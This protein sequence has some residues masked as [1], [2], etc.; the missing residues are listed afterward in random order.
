MQIAVAENF[1]Y[2]VDLSDDIGTI[3]L[4]ISPEQK[5]TMGSAAVNLLVASV[6]SGIEPIVTATKLIEAG[7]GT[8][9]EKFRRVSALAFPSP[10]YWQ[11]AIAPGA[12]YSLVNFTCNS[13]AGAGDKQGP[14]YV[15]MGK[16]DSTE[17][18][19]GW[20]LVHIWRRHFADSSY[21]DIMASL[22]R[23]L[24]A[25]HSD[26]ALNVQSVTR[27]CMLFHDVGSRRFGENRDSARFALV[28]ARLTVTLLDWSTDR[29][30]VLTHFP[31]TQQYYREKVDKGQWVV[32]KRQ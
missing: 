26:I 17:A 9:L 11:V 24:V 32:C 16:Q 30:H 3:T 19:K 15:C 18:H 10:E 2:A 7:P 6:Y 13:Y 20:G 14:I 22:R 1:F 5:L 25:L 29:F 4:R 31:S 8:F 28:D 27:Y 23:S 21:D 12:P